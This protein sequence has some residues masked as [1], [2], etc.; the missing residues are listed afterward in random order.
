VGVRGADVVVAGERVVLAGGVA[1]HHPGRYPE[2]A[3]HHGERGAELLAVAALL[4]E[5]EVLDGVHLSILGWDGEVVR[6]VLLEVLV[7]P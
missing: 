4:L 3:G 7:H 6:I 2:G 5:E 1:R